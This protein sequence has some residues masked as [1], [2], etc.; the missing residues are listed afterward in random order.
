ME[1]QSTQSESGNDVGKVGGS[2]DRAKAERLQT[3]GRTQPA[4]NV[5]NLL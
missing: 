2:G 1:W 4:K 3:I 5:E